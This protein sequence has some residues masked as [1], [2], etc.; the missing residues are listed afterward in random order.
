MTM[1]DVEKTGHNADRREMQRLYLTTA[2]AIAVLGLMLSNLIEIV[3]LGTSEPILYVG[4]T[5]LVL[6]L[7]GVFLPNVFVVLRKPLNRIDPLVNNVP[8]VDT[9]SRT[10]SS[11]FV[12]IGAALMFVGTQHHRAL[13]PEAVP[14]LMIAAYTVY[15]FR[16][17]FG[18][19]ARM[20]GIGGEVSPT[21]ILSREGIWLPVER[22][23]VG[24]AVTMPIAWSDVRSLKCIIKS[25]SLQNQS[26]L[27]LWV[28]DINLPGYPA[29]NL[30][31]SP[32]GGCKH[33]DIIRAIALLQPRL[34]EQMV[35]GTLMRGGEIVYSQAAQF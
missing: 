15:N 9:I 7:L 33:I 31:L 19:L 3:K 29:G 1:P 2:L 34:V 30:V 22:R 5:F 6:G 4:N 35:G 12:A 26:P 16:R 23:P 18:R 8:R 32:D 20:F 17:S 24:V 27:T 10:S 25:R 14:L 13:K 11:V 28:M 21:F